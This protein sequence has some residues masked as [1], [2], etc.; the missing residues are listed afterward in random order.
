MTEQIGTHGLFCIDDDDYAAYALAM[1]CNANA[2]DATLT[3]V[4]D[5]IEGYLGRPW[6]SGVN[7][8]ATVI[9][10]DAAGGEIGPTGAVGERI[11]S[12]S[13]ALS[14]NVLPVTSSGEAWPGGIYQIG[15]SINWTLGAATA[16]SYRQL[17]V[18]AVA[19]INGVINSATTYVDLYTMRDY[20]GDGGNNGALTVVGFLDARNVEIV[21]LQSFFSHGNTAGALTAAA[22]NWR[23]WATYLGSGLSI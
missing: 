7:N 19:R 3:T 13:V 17:M 6:L 10:D 4:N 14:G 8:F 20:Q 21:Q 1:Q 16:N 9:N 18:Y 2:T 5:A 23:M 22:G 12:G 15:A 11:G